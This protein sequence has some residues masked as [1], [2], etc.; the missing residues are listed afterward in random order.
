MESP[1]YFPHPEEYRQLLEARGFEVNTIE[2]IPRPTL[3]PGDV[4]GW[5]E[6][7][8]QPYTSALEADNRQ[9][10]VSELVKT[11]SKILCDANGQ[12]RADYVRLRFSAGKPNN[13]T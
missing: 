10:F 6:T 12:W 3:L 4:R 11:L 2:L 13:A 5:L 8:A 7:F 1:W 9:S